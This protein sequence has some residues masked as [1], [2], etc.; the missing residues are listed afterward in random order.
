MAAV[1][2]I[3]VFALLGSGTIQ[4]GAALRALYAVREAA[5]E[6][7]AEKEARNWAAI[8]QAGLRPAPDETWINPGHGNDSTLGAK[9][10]YLEEWR[11][12][13]CG[14]K[15]EGPHPGC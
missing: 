4:G 1:I 3:I 14:V 6:Q 7:W 15:A 2:T 13:G 12:R 11:A 10:P 5:A 8:E 9:R